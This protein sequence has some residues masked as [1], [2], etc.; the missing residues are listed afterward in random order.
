MI[1]GRYFS[2]RELRC[3]CGCESHG[4]TQE[5]VDKLDQLRELWGKPLVL[6][7]AYRCSKHPEEARKAKPGRHN[8][9]I[10]ADVA[11]SGYDQ[12][13]LIVLAHQLGFK[14]FGIANSF[15]HLDLRPTGAKWG[16]S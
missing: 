6:T 9:G 12:I 13:R 7:S 8:Q 2:A 5:L 11:V 1:Q 16:Y 10:A 14:G 15:V 4:V 3:K